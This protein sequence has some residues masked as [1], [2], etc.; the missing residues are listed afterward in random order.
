MADTLATSTRSAEDLVSRYGGEEFAIVLPGAGHR[1][2]RAVGERSRAAVAALHLPHPNSA[3][4]IVT[5][6]VGT[7]AVDPMA[8]GLGPAGPSTAD[9]ERIVAAADGPL[10]EAK[11]SGRN[12]VC[13]ALT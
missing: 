3:A 10:Y 1:A 2:T 6:S 4:R 5:V 11:K 9:V 8:A 13:S 12:R 7:N